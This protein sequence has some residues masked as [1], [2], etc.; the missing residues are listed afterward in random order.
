MMADRRTAIGNRNE[1][2]TLPPHVVQPSAVMMKSATQSSQYGPLW[3]D[4]QPSAVPL[5]V[6]F[7]SSAAVPM[8]KGSV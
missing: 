1:R 7:A 3:P 6:A 2:A 4:L 8:Q 5:M